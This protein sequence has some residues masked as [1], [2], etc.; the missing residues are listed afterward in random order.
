MFVFRRK[1]GVLCFP[2]TPDLRFVLFDICFDICL[3]SSFQ[4]FLWIFNT[5]EHVLSTLEKQNQSLSLYHK[6][7]SAAIIESQKNSNLS[8]N[9]QNRFRR[10]FKISLIWFSLEYVLKERWE[11]T[12]S[13]NNRNDVVG[14]LAAVHVISEWHSFFWLH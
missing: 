3:Q 12:S 10:G 6:H 7:F 5:Y 4:I 13:R 11:H 1:F 8:P 14:L 9:H 2:G